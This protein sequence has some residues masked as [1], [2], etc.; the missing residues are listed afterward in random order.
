MNNPKYLKSSDCAA[1]LGI[2]LKYFQNEYVFTSGLD[3]MA[4]KSATGHRREWL[5]SNIDKFINKNRGLK[6]GA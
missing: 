2:S 1:L 5:A 6:R 3:M 4:V